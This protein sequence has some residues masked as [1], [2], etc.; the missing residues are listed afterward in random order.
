MEKGGFAYSHTNQCASA[1]PRAKVLYQD[2]ARSRCL[3][4]SQQPSTAT[5]TTTTRRCVWGANLESCFGG[6]TCFFVLVTGNCRLV[7]KQYGRTF[8]WYPSHRGTHIGQPRKRRSRSRRYPTTPSGTL[9]SLTSSPAA[10]GSAKSTPTFETEP[11]PHESSQTP[12]GRCGIFGIRRVGD[13]ARRRIDC[14]VGVAGG[15]APKWQ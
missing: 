9:S 11:L 13:L 10:N 8:S 4:D 7:G 3:F 12:G 14:R 1:Q 15:L 2:A 5:A 6:T